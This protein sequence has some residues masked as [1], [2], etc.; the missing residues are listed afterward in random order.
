[1][2]GPSVERCGPRPA[3]VARQPLQPPHQDR[4]AEHGRV[5]PGR[6][7]PR[8]GQDLHQLIGKPQQGA[9]TSGA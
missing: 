6:Q 4:G 8:E 1:M 5:D 9:P 2:A 3:L 7:V